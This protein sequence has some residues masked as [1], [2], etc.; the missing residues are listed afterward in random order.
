MN[1]NK[2]FTR[3]GLAVVATGALLAPAVAQAAGFF[4]T[5][6]TVGSTTVTA[7]Q[8]GAKESPAAVMGA[9]FKALRQNDGSCR[10][11]YKGLPLDTK[12]SNMLLGNTTGSRVIQ[13]ISNVYNGGSILDAV[14]ANTEA[15]QNYEM[16]A[17]RGGW[18]T[19][20][21]QN[22]KATCGNLTISDDFNSLVNLF[23]LDGRLPTTGGIPWKSTNDGFTGNSIGG[24]SAPNGTDASAVID[25]EDRSDG[26]VSANI[27]PD[28][29]DGIVAR[30]TENGDQVEAY[31]HKSMDKTTTAEDLFDRRT[32]APYN[33]WD[34]RTLTR[35]Y[36]YDQTVTQSWT[37]YTQYTNE[38]KTSYFYYLDTY[39]KFYQQRTRTYQG[40]C[41][42]PSN[43]QSAGSNGYS[44]GTTTTIGKYT[45]LRTI[46]A[47]SIYLERGGGPQCNDFD[48][49]TG[50][51]AG[52][53]AYTTAYAGQRTSDTNCPSS[54]KP[55]GGI[56]YQTGAISQI[57]TPTPYYSSW[58]GYSYSYNGSSPCPT[59][60]TQECTSSSEYRI[61]SYGTPIPGTSNTDERPYGGAS[62]KV[63]RN[64]SST[65]S[66]VVGTSTGQRTCTPTNNTGTTG[67][68]FITCQ[69]NGAR[70]ASYD[71]GTKTD[72]SK[73]DSNWKDT[74]EAGTTYTV[75][76]YNDR[77]I[78]T[79]V[80]KME[81]NVRPCTPVNEV[82][83]D[84]VR[85]QVTCATRPINHLY[86]YEPHLKTCST[87]GNVNITCIPRTYDVTYE[88]TK[89]DVSWGQRS[90][91]NYTEWNRVTAG[92]SVD[93]FGN[94][95]IYNEATG[96]LVGTKYEKWGSVPT[97]NVPVTW[98]GIKAAGN[99]Y[100]LYTRSLANPLQLDTKTTDFAANGTGWGIMHTADSPY[101]GSAIDNFKFTR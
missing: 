75:R 87:G 43:N 94:T 96:E 21:A 85:T 88:N 33:T 13:T 101:Q 76:C 6:S 49:P 89:S 93:R 23:V 70:S 58:S 3:L 19:H 97:G 53:T 69:N 4:S 25:T 20:G 86:T 61:D 95:P 9:D 99:T 78:A 38:N 14:V 57:S 10:V 59:T 60:A 67:S 82:F 79:I 31:L 32:D 48:N 65:V 80:D 18:Y 56:C 30:R 50:V 40:T 72:I 98:L 2:R 62:A 44:W 39:Y 17:T 46:G 7:G 29:G 51:E 83:G 92:T 100:T 26:T 45:I 15:P 81:E 16:S 37:D 34:R 27:S 11:Y 5:E 74:P 8:L 64:T 1:H 90:G 28:G 84:T 77:P 41:Y 42:V 35:E 47:G 54:T 73:C 36:I 12:A 68:T 63:A 71:P 66:Q 91:G 52:V 55:V 22:A 24:V